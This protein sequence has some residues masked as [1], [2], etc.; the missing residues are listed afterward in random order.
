MRLRSQLIVVVAGIA[1]GLAILL[2]GV[3][4][5]ALR[6]SLLGQVDDSLA[7]AADLGK[8]APRMEEMPDGVD[9]AESDGTV[10]ESEGGDAENPQPP[11]GEFAPPWGGDPST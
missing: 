3:S 2:G 6:A 4:T 10:D 8:N 7:S 1:M 9:P 11:S 5:L